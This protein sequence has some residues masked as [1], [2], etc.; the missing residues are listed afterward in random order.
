LVNGKNLG[1]RKKKLT[2]IDPESL[3]IELHLFDQVIAK[4]H[5][6]KKKD[7]LPQILITF[8]AT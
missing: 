8:N 2:G 1:S 7:V 6:R 4:L 5:L 3:T